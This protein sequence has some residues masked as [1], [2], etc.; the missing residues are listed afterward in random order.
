MKETILKG[1][2]D[3]QMVEKHVPAPGPAQKPSNEV[4]KFAKSLLY[5]FKLPVKSKHL[6]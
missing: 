3:V 1:P 5:C 4:Y 6:K 2:A